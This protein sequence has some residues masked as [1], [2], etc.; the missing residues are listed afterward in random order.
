M[1][2]ILNNDNVELCYYDNDS[3][4]VSYCVVVEMIVE[5]CCF[6][7]VESTDRQKRNNFK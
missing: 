5:P 4:Y 7:A 3:S 1:Y 2:G 6:I